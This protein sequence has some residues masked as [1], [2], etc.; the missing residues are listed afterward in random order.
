MVAI[1]GLLR[2]HLSSVKLNKQEREREM[3]SAEASLQDW[4]IQNDQEEQDGG[5]QQQRDPRM[6]LTPEELVWAWEIK[7]VVEGTPELNN[8]TDFWYGQ[9]ALKDLGDVEASLK[10]VYHLQLFREEHDIM[11]T[12]NACDRAIRKLIE[13]LPNYFMSFSLNE[14]E[15]G[16]CLVNDYTGWDMKVLS[17]G[18]KVDEWIQGNYFMLNA[19]NPDF[20]SIRNGV[21]ALLECEGFGWHHISIQMYKKLISEVVVPYPFNLH[22]LKHYHTG[23]FINVLYSMTKPMFSESI[24]QKFQLGCCFDA[25]LSDIYMKPTVAAAN[26][27]LLI[28]IKEAITRR[29]A[30][31]SSFSLP[32]LPIPTGEEAVMNEVST[33]TDSDAEESVASED[34]GAE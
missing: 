33:G 29:Y 6:E 20:A 10:R 21:I 32:P 30:M 15:G 19:M 3:A 26:K 8:L 24:K 23:M 9:L 27:R 7:E 14:E 18:K 17:S 25:R 11:E 16:Y 28:K 22:S 2:T 31:E 4:R 34:E 13:M 1:S 5:E 12:A